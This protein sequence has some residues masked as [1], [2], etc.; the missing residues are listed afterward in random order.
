MQRIKWAS[1]MRSHPDATSP[2]ALLASIPDAVPAP[3]GVIWPHPTAHG[4][5]LFQRELLAQLPMM[6]WGSWL[7]DEVLCAQ[8]S[9]APPLVMGTL[10][11]EVE[12]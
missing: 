10:G 2:D 1:V 8:P 12:V 3:S 6:N 7:S 11:S 5:F 9:A 4:T